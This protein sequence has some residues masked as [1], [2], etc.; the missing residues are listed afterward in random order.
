MLPFRHLSEHGNIRY[1]ETNITDVM[2]YVEIYQ[3]QRH[4]DKIRV[5]EFLS[6]QRKHIARHG[7]VHFPGILTACQVRGNPKV[8]LIDGQHRFS[9][10]VKLTKLRDYGDFPVILQIIR[11]DDEDELHREFVNINK[12]IPVPVHVLNPNQIVS[13]AISRL[14][15]VYP[16]GF[17][18][19]E[20]YVRPYIPIGMFKDYLIE[21]GVVQEKA[22]SSGEELMNYIIRTNN[23]IKKIGLKKILS[24][25]GGKNK[26]KRR[27]IR[28]MYTKAE[29]GG[30]MY[31]GMYLEDKWGY[32]FDILMDLEPEPRLEYDSDITEEDEGPSG[33]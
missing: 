22:I 9:T 15:A 7:C 19:K 11:V 30:S 2:E 3:G 21:K 5:N 31:I 10:M 32:W 26:S 23:A 18:S 16:K 12:S 33:Y 24:N 13:S 17:S 8:I 1:V 4:V 14:S 6:F 27:I 29:N 20:K 28:N 25:L